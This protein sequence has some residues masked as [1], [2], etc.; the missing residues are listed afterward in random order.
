MKTRK[1]LILLIA[2]IVL[3]GLI[4]I[5]ERPFEDKAEKKEASAALFFPALDPTAVDKLRIKRSDDETLNITK[6]DGRWVLS[7]R[8][9]EY[10]ADPL[11]VTEAIDALQQIKE[12]NLASRQQN[13][14]DLFEVTE[15]SSREVTLYDAADKE[16][17]HLFIGKS[18]PDFFSTYIRK[19]GTADVYLS[20]DFP[21][22]L[23]DQPATTW[24]DKTLLAFNPEEVN[25]VTISKENET[26]VLSKD[27]QGNWHLEK[28]IS[29]LADSQ[30]VK[31]L[32][33]GLSTLT[34]SDYA[35]GISLE[36]S[37]LKDPAIRIIM[38]LKDQS[39]NELLI[40]IKQVDDNAYYVK[41]GHR[42]YIYTL[43]STIVDRISPEVITLEKANIPSEETT[44]AVPR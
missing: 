26:I 3:A 5:L 4:L 33:T 35:D 22:G 19:A 21:K 20:D 43:H 32:L 41:T 12:L 24:R 28:P 16:V 36:E 39:V 29:S 13:K 34:A 17:A 27:S 9:K 23:F 15:G 2:L 30:K 42:E 1:N 14:H 25:A 40:G 11:M 8:E 37:G 7:Y 10:P 44:A 6:R 31:E 18:G 38:T